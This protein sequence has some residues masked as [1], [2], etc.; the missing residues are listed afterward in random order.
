[1]TRKGVDTQRRHNHHDAN[2]L[3]DQRD[4]DL[5]L[6]MRRRDKIQVR[7]HEHW[8]SNEIESHGC[9]SLLCLFRVSCAF[10]DFASRPVQ[11]RR[12]PSR[13]PREHVREDARRFRKRHEPPR[14]A[15][16]GL[17]RLAVSLTSGHCLSMSSGLFYLQP[18]HLPHLV[19]FFIR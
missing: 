1:M 13:G 8:F 6:E 11:P 10:R 9:P 7:D 12:C 16:A 19:P 15:V 14:H 2:I 4:K 3:G 18:T 17:P 5:S